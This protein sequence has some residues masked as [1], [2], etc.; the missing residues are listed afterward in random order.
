MPNKIRSLEEIVLP[1]IAKYV[2][3][4]GNSFESACRKVSSNNLGRF[5]DAIKNISEEKVKNYIKENA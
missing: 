1:Q 2:H 3:F 5:D 4:A